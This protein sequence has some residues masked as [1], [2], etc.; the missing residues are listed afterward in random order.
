[1]ATSTGQEIFDKAATRS[2]I[3]KGRRAKWIERKGGKATGFRYLDHNGR[4]ITDEGTLDRIKSLVIPPAW[5][6][7]RI[8]PSA[9][10]RLQVVGMDTRGRIQ[11]RYHPTFSKQQERKKFAKVE[12]F[13]RALPSLR[14]ATSEHLSLEGMPKEKVLA[15]MLRLINSLYFRVGT[16]L[17]EKAYKTYGITTLNKKHLSI[18]QKGKLVFDFVGKSHVQHRKVLVDEELAA[19]IKDIVSLPRGGKLFRFLDP[20]GKPRTVKPS[21]I[22]AYLK[23]ITDPQFSSKDFRTWGGT[24]LAANAL[25]EIGRGQTEAEIKK[26]VVKAVKQVAEELGNTPAVCRSS[27]IHPAVIQAYSAGTTIDQFTPRK[28]RRI[29]R[30]QNGLEP[31]E[32]ALLKMLKML[33]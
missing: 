14:S 9:N 2:M 4:I 11:Y 5:Q 3:V 28:M 12:S 33:T 22:N 24:L 25:A 21:E 30:S 6:N 23:A 20:Q 10:G 13:G 16:E 7:V 32:E 1:M 17:S 18:K 27:Y 26:N 15:A 8:C 31:D 19:V 29:N